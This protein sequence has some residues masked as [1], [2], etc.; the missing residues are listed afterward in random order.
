MK[1]RLETINLIFLSD[2]NFPGSLSKY[3]SSGRP[4]NSTMPNVSS[5]PHLTV[6][7]THFEDERS[8]H[9]GAYAVRPG[10][11]EPVEFL[12][13]LFTH[14]QGLDSSGFSG[15][16]PPDKRLLPNTRSAPRFR[17]T[18]Y[19][20]SL[21]TT[22]HRKPGVYTFSPRSMLSAEARTRL[23]E[24]RYLC[25]HN[26]EVCREMGELQKADVWS[27]LT[28][29][30]DGRIAAAESKSKMWIVKAADALASNFISSTL[31]FFESSGDVQML[32]TMVCVLRTQTQELPKS[33]RSTCTFLP[34]DH[35][36]KYDSYIRI[37]ASL[38]YA[39]GL[40]S[41]RVELNKH[42]RPQWQES[43]TMTEFKI[44]PSQCIVCGDKNANGSMTCASCN[45]FMFRCVICENAVKGFFTWCNRCGHGG[46]TSHMME[47]FQ[48]SKECP[49]GCGCQCVLSSSKQEPD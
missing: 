20:A 42:L 6:R 49:T 30:V 14:Q 11:Q 16:L 21:S 38:L 26:A 44:V 46:H 29:I 27:V 9:G 23:S 36:G 19:D 18:P 2:N 17:Q 12:R 34:L 39:W 8:V 22:Q 1:V 4:H 35:S 25:S 33:D 48:V 47:F 41:P 28:Q 10:M 32:A 3:D 43:A 40:L 31:R 45:D 37:Y 24:T 13:K 15:L 7:T 5:D